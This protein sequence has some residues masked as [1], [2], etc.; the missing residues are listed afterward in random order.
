MHPYWIKLYIFLK[1]NRTDK[2]FQNINIKT[3]YTVQK[4][5]F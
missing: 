2:N 4:G 3:C 1:K 5:F